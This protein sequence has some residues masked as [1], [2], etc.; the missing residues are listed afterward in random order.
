MKTGHPDTINPQDLRWRGRGVVPVEDHDDIRPLQ[1]PTLDF[2]AYR[3]SESLRVWGQLASGATDP[4]Q[5]LGSGATGGTATEASILNQS[6]NSR[7]GLMFQILDVQALNRLGRLWVR[8]NE[9]HITE[10]KIIELA[11]RQ[12][13]GEHHGHV[14]QSDEVVHRRPGERQPEL[15]GAPQEPERGQGVGDGG[16]DVGSHDHGHRQLDRQGSGSDQADDGGRG[17]R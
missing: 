14:A 15:P 16:P 5:G 3:E 9:A 6:A 13:E 4:F 7:A 12:F 2:A 10:E 17:H 8:L 11:G 1:P